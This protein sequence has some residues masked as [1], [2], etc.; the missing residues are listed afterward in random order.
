M[1]WIAEVLYPRRT[2]FEA[3]FLLQEKQPKNGKRDAMAI[4]HAT[5]YNRAWTQ[6]GLARAGQGSMTTNC[7]RMRY[8]TSKCY[9]YIISVLVT[10]SQWIRFTWRKARSFGILSNHLCGSITP[11]NS[12]DKLTSRCMNA[13]QVSEPNQEHMLPLHQEKSTPATKKH[14]WSSSLKHGSVTTRRDSV[15]VPTCM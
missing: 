11:E 15:G 14:A 5:K 4:R 1:T 8:I 10:V 9:I 7:V 13:K 2:R 6:L 3:P 12:W